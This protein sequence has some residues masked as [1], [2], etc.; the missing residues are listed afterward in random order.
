MNVSTI[1][2]SLQL[3][4]TPAFPQAAQAP[5]QPIPAPE[6]AMAAAKPITRDQLAAAVER[7]NEGLQA[8]GAVRFAMHEDTN[9]IIVRVINPQTQEIIREFPDTH[10]LDMVAKLQELSGLQVNVQT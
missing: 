6:P 8:D 5:A 1:G 10:F 2:S 9:R 4:Q 7:A 3:N